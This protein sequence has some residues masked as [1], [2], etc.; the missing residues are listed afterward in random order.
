MSGRSASPRGNIN[1][2]YFPRR[3]DLT[4]SFPPKPHLIE[5][6]SVKEEF[7]RSVWVYHEN[8]NPVNMNNDYQRSVSLRASRRAERNNQRQQNEGVD[9]LHP[10]N[11]LLLAQSP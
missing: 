4:T 7:G 6:H 2:A 8:P 1:K 11:I 9:P 10:Q 5:T 3:S